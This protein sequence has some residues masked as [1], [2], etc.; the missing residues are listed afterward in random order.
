[1]LYKDNGIN[2]TIRSKRASNSKYENIPINID[3]TVNNK[4]FI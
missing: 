1:M 3:I 4:M 2:K